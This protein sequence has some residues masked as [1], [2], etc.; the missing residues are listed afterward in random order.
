M[1]TRRR[2]LRYLGVILLSTAFILILY[3]N[4]SSQHAESSFHTLKVHY[5]DVGQGDAILIEDE[6]YDM[7]IDAG[8]NNQGEIVLDYLE[9]E[10]ITDLDYVIGTHPHEDHIGGMD[11]VLNSIPVDTIIL[12]NVTYDT[13]TYKDVLRAI[14]VNN[15]SLEAAT[16]GDEYSLGDATFTIIAPNSSY[17]EDMNNYSICLKLTHGNNTFLFTGDAEEL[18]ER[19]MLQ[20]GVDLSADV[21][22]LGHHGSAYSSCEDFLTAV[23]PSIGVISVGEDNDY[24]HPHTSILKAMIKHNINVYRTDQQG[25]IIITSDGNQLLVNHEA[26]DLSDFKE[27]SPSK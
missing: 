14:V 27:K 19:E 16:A 26:Y 8:G 25:S 9:A 24:G 13:K 17:Y 4:K 20:S 11:T 18:S 6:D 7:L 5:I 1:N 22:K 10:H 21:L 12:P 23:N 2:I 3:S 15:V